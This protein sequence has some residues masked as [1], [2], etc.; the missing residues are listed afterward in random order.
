MLKIKRMIQ[1]NAKAQVIVGAAIF[2]LFAAISVLWIFV[3]GPQGSVGK[4]YAFFYTG[5]PVKISSEPFYETRPDLDATKVPNL[6]AYVCRDLHP[7]SN[8]DFYVSGNSICGPCS[9]DGPGTMRQPWCTF[10][11]AFSSRTPHLEGSGKLYIREGKYRF[12]SVAFGSQFSAEFRDISG[13]PN[14]PTVISGYPGEKPMI[15]FSDKVQGWT[16]YSERPEA[17][18]WVFDWK[19]QLQVNH[20]WQYLYP[21]KEGTRAPQIVAIDE[22]PIVLFQ[23]INSLKNGWTFSTSAADSWADRRFPSE[24][25]SSMGTDQSDMD[26]GTTP[27]FYYESDRNDPDF[28]KLFIWLPDGSN[29]NNRQ[30][31]VSVSP[32]M[33]F[34]FADHPMNYIHI[35]DL[36]FRFGGGHFGA[37]ILSGS[38]NRFE[39]LDSSYH[40]FTGLAGIC[41]NCVVKNSIFRFNGDASSGLYG[42]N[43]IYE[44]NIMEGNN[45]R[46]YNRFWH[47]GGIK[48]AQNVGLATNNNMVF[49][50][51]LVKNNDGWGVWFDGTQME[52]AVIEGNVIVNNSLDG[53][54]IEISGGTTE[55]P[56]KIRNNILLNNGNGKFGEELDFYGGVVL[57]GSRYVIVEN[58][59]VYDSP[60]GVTEVNVETSEYPLRQ[61]TVQNNIFLNVSF[62]LTVPRPVAAQAEDNTANNNIFMNSGPSFFW[63]H[64]IQ[65]ATTWEDR[66]DAAAFTALWEK[67]DNSVIFC[68]GWCFDWANNAQNF[69]QWQ[70]L[71]FDQNSVMKAPRA[72]DIT[73]YGI[74]TEEAPKSTRSVINR[75]RQEV[76]R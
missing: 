56:A 15:Y 27:T 50:N 72:F 30:I 41:K 69:T 51:N 31:E 67:L 44:S 16:K 26:Q 76:L 6:R 54:R 71:G 14:N 22:N 55:K 9:D 43:T 21:Y 68:H 66:D 47:A 25:T 20:T 13:T 37:V 40:G 60:G 58:N 63:D 53:I 45:V 33:P 34:A 1:R 12:D 39:N 59:L 38:Y 4:A 73:K 17:N 62:P 5:E 28:G 42:D 65:Y 35:K 52:N 3:L 49:R 75:I 29:P 64:S 8:K 46:K 36:I 48:F 7:K 19:S 24:N 57:S 61:N 10:E 70:S 18:I 23:E 32:A 11:R 2:L 74:S